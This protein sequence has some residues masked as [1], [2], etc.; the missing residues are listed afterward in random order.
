MSRYGVAID[1]KW[2][3]RW[4]ESGIYRF[5]PEN[6]DK[7]LYCLEMFSYPS[8]AN[9]HIGHWWNFGMTDCWA[10]MHRMLGYEI[11]RPMGFDSFGLPAENYAIKTGVHPRDSTLASIATMQRQL[12]EIGA[13]YDWDYELSTCDEEYYRWTQWIFLQLFQRDLAYRKE[14]P[15]NWCPSCQTVLANEQ[16]HDGACE[17]CHTLVVRRDLTQWFFK[18]TAYAEEL[19]K[20]LDT[21]DWPEKTKIMQKNWIGRSEGSFIDFPLIGHQGVIRNFTTRADTLLGATYIVLAPEHPLVE[22]ITSAEYLPAVKAYQET[23]AAQ[24]E[25]DRLTNTKEKTGV[26]T[27]G[28]ASHPVTHQKLPVWIADYVLASYGTGSVMAVPGHDTRDYE[29]AQI[30]NLPIPRVITPVS[31][32]IDGSLPFVE[33]GLLVNSGQFDGLSSLEA[34]TKITAFLRAEEKGEETVTYRLRD[35]LVSRQRYWGA[36]VPIIHCPQCGLVPVPEDQLP[37]KLP[38]DV[39]FTPDGKSPL[40]KSDSFM[41]TTCPICGQAAQRDPDTL[42][43]FVD[44]SWYFLRYP[45]NHNTLQ[46]WDPAWIN[47]M[48]PVDRYVGGPEHACMHLLYARFI[49]KALRDMGYLQF[50]EPFTSLFHQGIILGADGAR[51]SKSRGNTIAPDGYVETYG[52]DVLRLFLGFGFSY[53]D[54]GPW[55]VDEKGNPSDDG[56]RGI[57][58][59]VD[60]LER[61]IEIISAAPGQEQQ[62][63]SPLDKELNFVR[64]QAIKAITR[65]LPLYQFNTSIAQ[66]MILLN[67]LQKYDLEATDPNWSLLLSISEDLLRL[68]APL[69]PHLSEELWASLGHNSSIHNEKWPVHDEQALVRDEIEYAVQINGKVR[70]RVLL[71]SDAN[72]EVIRQ[73]ALAMAESLPETKGKTIL[74]IIIVPKR[75]VNIVVA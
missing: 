16:V 21:L 33:D 72:E 27:G 28:Y 50:D 13:I 12:R 62:S 42:D 66:L 44:S 38:Y 71:P 6:A 55:P 68:L 56:I 70:S 18:T 8:A 4:E 52:S 7:K 69:A 61:W 37:V 57:A 54:G 36:P 17:R 2:Q 59:F 1:R 5:N 45:D 31:P 26:F 47:R 67:A 10:R 9:L 60:R 20:T 24:S 11:F 63:A 23:T 32:D 30:H 22:I 15:V 43:T 34:R 25:L 53:S 58:R 14:A 65:D 3:K 48:L 51:M 39:Q 41:H 74:K 46:A 29:F 40:A 75:L 64:H 19:T 73:E 35:W 49:T